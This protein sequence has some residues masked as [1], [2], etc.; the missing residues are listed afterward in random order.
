ME[1][2]SSIPPIIGIVAIFFMKLGWL[3][4]IFVVGYSL[5]IVAQYFYSEYNSR[6][7]EV[8]A[9]LKDKRMSYLS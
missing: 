9:K 3:G 8:V 4:L 1:L 7:L 2:V 5:V 6:N